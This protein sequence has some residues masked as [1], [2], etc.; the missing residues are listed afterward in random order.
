MAAYDETTAIRGSRII[1]RAKRKSTSSACSLLE[2]VRL[3]SGEISQKKWLMILDPQY[4]N[5]EMKR[6]FIMEL[7]KPLPQEE[8]A[9][10]VAILKGMRL[11]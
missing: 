3:S 9:R 10:R 8:A 6:S 2:Q 1:T 11:G 7:K 5:L 4:D